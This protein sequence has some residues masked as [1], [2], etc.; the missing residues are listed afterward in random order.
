MSEGKR[1]PW[2]SG[3][4]I[5][6]DLEALLL[7]AC[8]RIAVAGSIRRGRPDI[9]DIDLVC[10]PKIER[11]PAGLFGDQFDERDLLHDL[12]CRLANEGIIERRYDKNGR[13]AWGSNLKRATYRGLNVDLQMVT[14]RTTWGAWLLIRTGPASFNKA[15]VTPRFQGGLLP[16]GFAWKDGFKLYRPGGRVETPT[17]ESVFEALELPYLAPPD[18]DFPRVG[19]PAGARL[20]GMDE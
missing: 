13:P 17:E 15:I 11:Q 20:P 8:E 12:C 9:G 6:A 7:P 19:Q 2:E 4:K 3:A 16:S 5:A 1:V 18:R 14:D 10:E